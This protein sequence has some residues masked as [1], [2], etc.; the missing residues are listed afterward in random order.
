MFIVLQTCL[1]LL[2]YTVPKLV[3]QQVMTF[4]TNSLCTGSPTLNYSAQRTGAVQCS[5]KIQHNKPLLVSCGC[6]FLDDISSKM[7]CYKQI[8]CYNFG[9][10][11]VDICYKTDLY[12]A[13]AKFKKEYCLNTSKLCNIH[14]INC[15]N[16]AGCVDPY[17]VSALN[18]FSMSTI[19]SCGPNLMYTVFKKRKRWHQHINLLDESY[20]FRLIL[21]RYCIETN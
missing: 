5:S 17:R 15:K 6:H 2:N 4:S 1:K 20:S 19:T 10:D 7:Q 16:E 9:T 12:L 11:Y 8:N 3:F 18:H 14:R 13:V 21:P